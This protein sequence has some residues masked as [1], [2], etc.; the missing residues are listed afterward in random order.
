[1]RNRIRTSRRSV[2]HHESNFHP[3]LH[4]WHHLS[5]D[6]HSRSRAELELIAGHHRDAPTARAIDV[7]GISARGARREEPTGGCEMFPEL[8]W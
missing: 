8:R 3:Y 2:L 7:R 5:A 4:H 6:P 1:M